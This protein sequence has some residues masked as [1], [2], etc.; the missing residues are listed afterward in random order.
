MSTLYAVK[1]LIHFRGL[2]LNLEVV[3]VTPLGFGTD[4][5]GK[6]VRRR[7]GPTQQGCRWYE[8]PL[9]IPGLKA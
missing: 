3:A 4:C 2:D 8:R 9:H 5:C 6:D 7:F 1:F